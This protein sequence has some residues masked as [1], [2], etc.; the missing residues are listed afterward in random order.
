MKKEDVEK[1]R[2]RFTFWATGYRFT[3]RH[4]LDNPGIEVRIGKRWMKDGSIQDLLE[5]IENKENEIIQNW[6]CDS[7]GNLE[8][9][10]SE[11]MDTKTKMYY[12]DFGRGNLLEDY[13]EEEDEWGKIR[14]EGDLIAE[15]EWDSGGP[16]AGAGVV[17]VY[18][19][20]GKYY[21]DTDAGMFE[22]ETEE[23]AMLQIPENEATVSTTITMIRKK[24]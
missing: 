20:E 6:Q 4:S 1:I 7:L 12:E 9:A 15:Q 18:K 24:Y 23:E 14:N 5:A 10:S 16:G 3:W 17:S 13:E 2:G 19:F 11:N 22:Y 8:K 21:V